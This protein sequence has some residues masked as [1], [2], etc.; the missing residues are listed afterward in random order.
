VL[1]MTTTDR[2]AE[3]ARLTSEIETWLDAGFLPSPRV[4][5]IYRLARRLHI[6]LDAKVAEIR[7]ARSA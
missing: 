4:A 3:L 2:A 5:R 1:Y 7:I 6:D